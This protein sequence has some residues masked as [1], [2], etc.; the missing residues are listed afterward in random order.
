MIFGEGLEEIGKE[1]FRGC[2]SLHEIII[3]PLDKAIKT[4]A[5]CHSESWRLRTLGRGWKKLG[6][7]HFVAVHRYIKSTSPH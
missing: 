4:A 5:F 2:T 3:P 6:T 1:A 7:R